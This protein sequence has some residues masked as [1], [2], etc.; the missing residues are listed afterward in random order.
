[1]G[2]TVSENNKRIARNTILL[3]VRMVITMCIGLFTSRIVLQNLGVVD[4]GINNVVAGMVTMFTF[5]NSTLATGTQRFITFALGERD[6]EKCKRTFSTTFVVHLVMAI[7]LSFVILIGGL[8][9]MNGQLSIPQERMDAAYWVFYTAI[10]TILLNITQV[11]YMSTIIAHENMSVYAYMAI[12]DA[13]AKLIVAFS[14][15]FS[16]VDNLKLFAILNLIISG[17][18]ILIYRIYCI[19][20]YEECTVSWQVD[21]KLLKSILGFSGWNVFGCAAVIMN[22]QG[23][24]ILLNMFFGPIVNAARGISNRLN[25]IVLQLVQNFQTAANPQIVKY[26]AGG[27]DDRMINLI[28]NNARYAGLLMAFVLVPLYVEAPFVLKIWLGEVPAETVFFTRII[29]IQSL[30]QTMS[31]PVVMGIHAVG[32]M[33]AVNILAGGNLLLILP[34]TWIMLKLGIDLETVLIINIIPWLIEPMI[35]MV[36]LKKYIG[37]P[38]MRF[39]TY[40]YGNVLSISVISYI[41]TLLVHRAISNEIAAFFAA[42]ST[43]VIVSGCLIYYWGLNKTMRNTIKNKIITKFKKS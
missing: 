39:Y 5:L 25:S 35:E 9:F 3:Y 17:T 10:I 28:L 2:N 7:A 37:F 4:Y 22:N 41:L 33:K 8:W 27:E 23:V 15:M 42:C 34:A 18:S 43:S 16:T 38:I 11:P 20:K 21:K 30:I 6:I 32:N 31:R 13:V 26:H 14:L 24:N 36:L 29:L 40:V 12:Y 19:K 1:M